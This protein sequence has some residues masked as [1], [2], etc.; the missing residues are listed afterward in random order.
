MKYTNLTGQLDLFLWHAWKQTH[1]DFG[2][3]C[4]YCLEYNNWLVI[5]SDEFSMDLECQTPTYYD[6]DGD[7]AGICANHKTKERT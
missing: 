3:R 5:S 1:T 6:E 4:A 7:Y 2:G